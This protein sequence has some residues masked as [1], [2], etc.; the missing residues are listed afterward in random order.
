MNTCFENE[1]KV[2]DVIYK[3][4][5]WKECSSKKHELQSGNIEKLDDMKSHVAHKQQC[6]VNH[7]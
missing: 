2:I 4:K 7:E 6:L 5:K 1:G 3:I